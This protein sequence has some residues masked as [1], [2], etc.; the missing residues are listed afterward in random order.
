MLTYQQILDKVYDIF[1]TNGVKRSA[2]MAGGCFYGPKINGYGC[3]IGCVMNPLDAVKFDIMFSAGILQLSEST[4]PEIAA[5]YQQYFGHL[6]AN[7]LDMIQMWHDSDIKNGDIENR[8]SSFI[9]LVHRLNNYYHLDV[10][11]P[12]VN[13]TTDNVVIEMG[14]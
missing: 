6:N 12:T 5:T 10:L 8:K 11:V 2:N 1:V 14:C 9:Y 4:N 3:A 13:E 7:A